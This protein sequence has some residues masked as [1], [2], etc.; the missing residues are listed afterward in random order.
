[1]PPIDPD[2]LASKGKTIFR[3][4]LRISGPSSTSSV[5][6]LFMDGK[7]RKVTPDYAMTRW[8]NG[9]DS[10]ASVRTF[11]D[12]AECV[13]RLCLSILDDKT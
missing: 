4:D 1:V 13:G 8:R 6:K 12:E 7:R 9:T 11:E 5:L 3:Q 2:H 10:N